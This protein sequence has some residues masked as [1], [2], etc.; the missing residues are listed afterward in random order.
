[1]VQIQKNNKK[2]RKD[3]KLSVAISTSVYFG[4]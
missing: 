3:I 2:D 4:T 1:M